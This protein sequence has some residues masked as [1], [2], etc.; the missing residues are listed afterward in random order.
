MVLTRRQSSLSPPPADSEDDGLSISS[1]VIAQHGS[2]ARSR[3]QETP[4]GDDDIASEFSEVG[5]VQKKHCTALLR[6][7]PDKLAG[8][9]PQMDTNNDGVIDPAE[10]RAYHKK[11]KQQQEIRRRGTMAQAELEATSPSKASVSPL[12]IILCL[13]VVGACIMLGQPGGGDSSVSGAEQERR[14]KALEELPTGAAQGLR[15]KLKAMMLGADGVSQRNAAMLLGG[16]NRALLE[17]GERDPRD[18]LGL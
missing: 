2:L 11:K 3:L 16:S 12:Q 18:S 8:V 7:L 15:T 6:I 5:T 10:H 13:A 9:S 1:S 14:V 17:Q 4:G